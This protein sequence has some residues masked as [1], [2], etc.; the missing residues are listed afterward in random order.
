MSSTMHKPQESTMIRRTCVLVGLLALFLQGSSGGHML[1]VQHTRCA[2]HGELV[3]PGDAHPHVAAEHAQPDSAAVHG[4]PD[5]GSDKT[6]EH[7]SVSANRRDGL[8]AIV[9][10]PASAHVCAM[11]HGVAV[12]HEFIVTDPA[13]FRVAPKNSPPA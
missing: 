9:D 11:P 4:T 10:A 2:D 5:A 3:H 1:L 8:V 6:H 12:A 7:C 13:R